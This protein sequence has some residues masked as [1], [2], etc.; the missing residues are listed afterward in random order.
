MKRII[1]LVLICAGAAHA[2][3]STS[4][5]ATENPISQGSK[6]ISGSAAGTGCFQAGV[7]CWGDVRTT[8]GTPGLAFG[9]SVTG[10][11]GTTNCNDSVAVLSGS[12][13]SNQQACAVVGL[14]SSNRD[15]GAREFEIRIRV[16]ISPQSITGY[17]F[18]YGEGTILGST[19]YGGAVRWNGPL[20]NF[21]PLI[22]FSN[23]QGGNILP[24]QVGDVFCA[25]AT[26]STLTATVTRSGTTI[27]SLTTTDS[28]Y[29][30]GSMGIG[31]FD[32]F[33]ANDNSFGFSSFSTTTVSGG[34]GGNTFTAATC[35]QADVNGLIN[36]T[37]GS[38][39]HQAVDGDTINIPAGSCTWT[40]SISVPANIGISIIGSGTPN[41]LPTQFGAGTVNTTIQHGAIS[42]KPTFGNSLSRISTINFLP[43]CS[44]FQ[45]TGPPITV[46][47]T[48]AAGGCPN[49][50]LDNLFFP[51]NWE[52][53]QN[54]DGSVAIVTNM[55]G[56]ADHNSPG[57]VAPVTGNYLNFLNLG[58]GSW[59]GV[60]GFGDK[61]WASPTTFGTN[62]AFYLENNILQFSLG[63]DT[64]IPS[65][66]PNGGGARFVCR[67]NQS[68]NINFAG[69]CSGHGT[70][71]TGR[72]RGVLQWEGYYNTGTCAFPWGT[73]G[74][75]S[76]WPGRSGT[77]RSFNNNFSSGTA[78]ATFKGLT[79]LDAQR[80]WRPDPY[81]AC[82][83]GPS[84]TGGL[85][86]DTVDGSGNVATVYY[87]GTIGAVTTLGNGFVITDSNAN[88]GWTTNQWVSYGTPFSVFE[89]VKGGAEIQL[90]SGNTLTLFSGGATSGG[91]F[92]PAVG[93]AYQIR[94]AFVCIDQAARSNGALLTGA[95]NAP[96]LQSTGVTGPVT[97][98]LTPILQAND[99]LPAVAGTIG[100]QTTSLILGRDFD[101]EANNQTAQ[102]TSTTPFN[103]TLVIQPITSWTTSGGNCNINMASTTG[104][105]L[106]GSVIIVDA[107]PGSHLNGGVPVTPNGSYTNITAISSTQ[108][109]VDNGCGSGFGDG[110]GA[111]GSANSVP[112]GHGTLALRP[113]T[114]TTGVSYLA[115]DQ[116]TWDTS[117][118]NHQ[119]VF[120]T[121][122][123]TNT[124]TLSYTP[125]T[126]PH[127]LVTGV[128]TGPAVVF[129]PTSIN[130]G[131]VNLGVTSSPQSI[132]ITN[133]GGANLTW[134]N[135]STTQPGGTTFNDQP[136]GGTCPLANASGLTPGSSCT[137]NVTGM[138]NNTGVQNGTFNFPSNAPN[139]PQ[140]VP[141]SITGNNPAIPGVSI[142]PTSGA[143]GTGT[144]P[145][146]FTITSNGTANLVMG[147]PPATI[148]DTDFILQAISGQCTSAQSIAP[149][150][151]CKEQVGFTPLSVGA[152]SGSLNIFDN[153]TGSPQVIPL[154]GTGVATA[155]V[156]P[157]SLVFGNVIVNQ[158]G[159][160]N[161]IIQS[162]GNAPLTISSIV[163]TGANYT[164]TNNC[165]ASL[166]A[167]TLCTVQVAFAPAATLA[168]PTGQCV[169]AGTLT[170]TDN[171]STGSTQTVN[172]TG[173][174]ILV[175]TTSTGV[176]I[177]GAV[178]QLWSNFLCELGGWHIALRKSPNGNYWGCNDHPY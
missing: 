78:P 71:T 68:P 17:E 16:T 29:T 154:T 146:P 49:L 140:T 15:A 128:V 175:P 135:F 107:A 132:Q 114:C 100:S 147:S 11:C 118:G 157:L 173:S 28:T 138:T 145:I 19:L 74:C 127:P 63:T 43:G 65:P 26:G 38:Q 89:T 123:A 64:D 95:S 59:Q 136:G 44:T 32:S 172:A 162:T 56:V 22:S 37:G 57:D 33:N 105:F 40:G 83:G 103:G 174:G 70:D 8:G 99:T 87:S 171:S 96:V 21:T 163:M 60:G 151:T 6:W 46:N 120:Y 80:R 5:P 2:Q 31:F 131:S 159:N 10:T 104:L 34:G 58:H 86:F 129:G 110:A 92:I 90:Q 61:S 112:V 124:W 176:T 152:K 155:S 9:T 121:C 161:V 166:A 141:L 169:F 108:I 7:Q 119:G 23:P 142:A 134:T 158:S 91:A 126:Y 82:D 115:T 139:S 98:V 54:S 130:F 111:G 55:F 88:P 133:T 62:Q 75:G 45:C 76:A 41:T 81:G 36:N 12:W 93:D 79:A 69:F 35:N 149:A 101:A 3:Y 73:Q 97:Q 42:M 48:C 14:I 27:A 164:Q 102:T 122:T 143:F 160:Q 113:T 77:G 51:T 72:P 39:Q 20:S 150:S 66:S 106:H 47:G 116:G 125:F 85:A 109:T 30:G 170:I 177:Q 84:S 156:A 52:A 67:F 94:R 53:L 117:G 4:F 24:L 25:T 50:R 153:V 137:V 13:P 165:P 178:Q 144:T 167:G 18:N 168:C 1:F 148:T